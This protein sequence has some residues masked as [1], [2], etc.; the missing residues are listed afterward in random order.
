MG[1]LEPFEIK[2]NTVGARCYIQIS[3]TRSTRILDT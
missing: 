2:L 1:Q 3:L